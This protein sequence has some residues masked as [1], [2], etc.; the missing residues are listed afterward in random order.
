MSIF[1]TKILLATDGSS[2]AQLAASTAADLADATNS[3]LHILSVARGNPDPVYQI[4]EASLRYET[5]EQALEAI[6]GEAQ[7]VLDEQ[8][9]KVREAGGSVK[10]A[11]VRIGE[12]HDQ[13]IVHLADD[14][15]AG[16]IVMG[17]RGLGGMRRS[18]LGSVSDSVVRHAHCPVLVVRKEQQ[19]AG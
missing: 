2:E 8:V 7:K 15:G 13:A 14:L 5:Y 12:S 4:H 19:G 10:E 16:L 9:Q 11:H 1:P 6:K 18:L 3:E 17:S